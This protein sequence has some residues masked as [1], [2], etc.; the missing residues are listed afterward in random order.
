MYVVVQE[1]VMATPVVEKQ[2]VLGPAVSLV[3]VG[4]RLIQPTLLI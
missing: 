1:L 2:S 3:V 4:K